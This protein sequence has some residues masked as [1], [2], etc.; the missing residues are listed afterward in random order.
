[1]ALKRERPGLGVLV[2]SQH[3]ESR[4]AVDLLTAG[5]ARKNPVEIDLTSAGS[6]SGHSW[7]R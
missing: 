7:T 6:T 2:P 5:Y 1:M 4:H 3:V